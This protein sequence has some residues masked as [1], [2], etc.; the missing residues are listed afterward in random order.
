MPNLEKIIS[1]QVNINGDISD[2]DVANEFAVYFKHVFHST[3][4]NAV[5]NDYLCKRNE[6]VKDNS[7]SS[8]KCIES[9]TVELI[10]KCVKKLKLGKSMWT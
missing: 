1:K 5:Y 3:H 6:C 7:Q 8:Y 2:V 4:D 10:D 9:L